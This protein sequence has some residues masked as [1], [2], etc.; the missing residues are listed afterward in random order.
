MRSQSI[1]YQ[2]VPLFRLTSN[3]VM[4]LISLSVSVDSDSGASFVAVVVV[5][6][7]S[8]TTLVVCVFL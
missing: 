8:Q 7:I 2:L 1:S 6:W 4:A 3:A 5:N